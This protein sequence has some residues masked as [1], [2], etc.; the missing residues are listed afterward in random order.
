[1][2]TSI[3]VNNCA[4]TPLQ[5]TPASALMVMNSTVMGFLVQVWNKYYYVT[6]IIVSITYKDYYNDKCTT[7]FFNHTGLSYIIFLT[8]IMKTYVA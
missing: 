6:C 5:H 8:D 3:P 7:F 4:I 1:M 2:I